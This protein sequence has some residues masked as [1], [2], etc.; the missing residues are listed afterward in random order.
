MALKW[1][2]N[3]ASSKLHC[4]NRRK[5]YRCLIYGVWVWACACQEACEN[6]LLVTHKPVVHNG[7]SAYLSCKHG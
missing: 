5:T 6:E 7:L 4:F 2:K 1:L 3:P